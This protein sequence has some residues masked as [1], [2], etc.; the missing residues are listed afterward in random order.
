MKKMLPWLVS[1]LLAITLIVIVGIYSWSTLFG[2]SKSNDPAKQ[3]QE[4]V[5]D[6]SA[7]PMSADER[8]KVTSELNDIKT[9]I[10]DTDYVVML[11][12]SF[13][14]DSAQAKEEF[15]KL[16]DIQIK[17]LVNRA[18]W[19]L[20]P[21]ELSG[22]EGKDRLQAALINAINP[23]LTEGKLASVEITSFIMTQI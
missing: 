6:V 8:I 22:T 23:V 5:K 13:Q 21:E 15:D 11:S 4:S 7:K 12:L 20:K 17:P 9:N 2:D 14:L 1:L 19:V 3:T 10:A 16:K 18:L